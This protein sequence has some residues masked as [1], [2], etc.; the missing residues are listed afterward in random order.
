[1]NAREQS[2]ILVGKT[3]TVRSGGVEPSY[4]TDVHRQW[5]G[6]S[7]TVHAVVASHPRENPLVKVKLGP[8]QHVV[9]FRLADLEIHPDEP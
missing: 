9:F 2:D 7:G 8:D 6:H 4:Y 3:V 1:M 5:V